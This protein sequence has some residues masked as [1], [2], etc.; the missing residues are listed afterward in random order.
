MAGAGI[1]FAE[2]VKQKTPP[3]RGLLVHITTP[4]KGAKSEWVAVTF[5][6]KIILLRQQRYEIH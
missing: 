3:E 4:E 6:A 5:S 2:S 1:D